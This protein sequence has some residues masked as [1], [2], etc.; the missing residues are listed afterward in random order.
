MLGLTRL[1]R[2]PPATHT[3]EYST[4][5]GLLQPFKSTSVVQG[6]LQRITSTNIQT[7][8]IYFIYSRF[9][10]TYITN[11]YS[12]IQDLLQ[13]T[14]K[15]NI[16]S[17]KIYF[18]HSRF[19]LAIPMMRW[20]KSDAVEAWR[21]EELLPKKKDKRRGSRRRGRAGN[22]SMDMSMGWIGTWMATRHIGPG[23]RSS[24]LPRSP[25]PIPRPDLEMHNEEN[26]FPVPVPTGD[27]IP[28]GNSWGSIVEYNYYNK[29]KSC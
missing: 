26:L 23:E 6:L 14:S 11:K 17:F 20:R 22:T 15:I 29:K 24:S 18:G 3:N 12:V 25:K 28:A 1:I 5:H 21:S 7:F 8:K 27:P 16:Q 2:L 19:T 9:I 13:R 10:L 4:I